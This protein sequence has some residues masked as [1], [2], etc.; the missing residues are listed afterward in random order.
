MGRARN[1]KVGVALRSSQALQVIEDALEVSVKALACGSVEIG[2]ALGL[3]EIREESTRLV[4]RLGSEFLVG[5]RVRDH[6]VGESCGSGSAD[7]R[8][9]EVSRLR[10]WLVR[11]RL[12][13]RQWQL[14]NQPELQE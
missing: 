14:L 2:S 4:A 10:Q 9:E 7:H 13:S 3:R 5:K 8:L 6:G 11:L 12:D 1:W